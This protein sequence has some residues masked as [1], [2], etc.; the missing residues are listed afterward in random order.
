MLIEQFARPLALRFLALAFGAGAAEFGTVGRSFLLRPLL[1]GT[2][3]E[4]VQIDQIPHGRLRHS[5]T[6][7]EERM[8][9]TGECV[10]VP[11]AIIGAAQAGSTFI[12]EFP[13][14]QSGRKCC[15]SISY[16]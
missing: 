16:K 13:I 7:V 6:V 1:L 9:S 11:V 15:V 2:L 5:D 4:L 12:Y 14:M 8:Y 10:R 3:P